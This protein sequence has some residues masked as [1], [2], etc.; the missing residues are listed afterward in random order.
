M[1]P[2]AQAPTAPAQTKSSGALLQNASEADV[3][4]LTIDDLDQTEQAA[5][6]LAVD[7]EALKPIAWLNDKHYDTLLQANALDSTLARRIEAYRAC[8]Q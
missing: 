8:S 5:A 3:S 2:R 1:R 6:L 7:P 4:S